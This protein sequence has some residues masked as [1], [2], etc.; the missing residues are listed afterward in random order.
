MRPLSVACRLCG[1]GVEEFCKTPRGETTAPHRPRVE[2][3]KG[4][5]PER[6]G[7]LVTM[8]RA[9]RWGAERGLR[10]KRARAKKT[11]GSAEG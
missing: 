3:S 8:S 5:S 10:V 1:A 11:E 7:G 6:V 4:A 9:R 2:E